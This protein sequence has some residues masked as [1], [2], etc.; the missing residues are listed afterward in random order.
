MKIYQSTTAVTHIADNASTIIARE[1]VDTGYSNRDG[2]S[3]DRIWVKG[4]PLARRLTREIIPIEVSAC[5]DV[6]K[7]WGTRHHE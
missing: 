3:L 4:H 1:S 7:N 5:A 2:P 6:L